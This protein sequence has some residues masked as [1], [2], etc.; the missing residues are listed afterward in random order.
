MMGFK[1]SL[2]GKRIG[3]SPPCANKTFT[4]SA[5]IIVL[6]LP[7]LAAATDVSSDFAVTPPNISEGS[8]PFVM[9]SLSV[10]LTQQG[11]AYTDGEQ[12]YAGG[13]YCP[14]RI[15]GE[16]ICYTSNETYLGYFDPKKCYVYDTSGSNTGN[17]Q[18][19]TGP[20]TGVSPHH[21]RPVGYTDNN[22]QCSSGH[23]YFS[24]NFMNWATMTALD[25]FRGVMT[26][27]ARLVDT[28]GP[29]A[30]TLL[31]RTHRY[32]DWKFVPKKI[33]S[34][35]HGPSSIS[36]SGY[37]FINDA[38][39]LTPFS[40]TVIS[41]D[42]GIGTSYGNRVKF[43]NG[44][45][46]LLGE[47]NVIV[48]VCNPSVGIEDNCTEYTDAGGN[49][50]YKPEGVIQ[51]HALEMR[52]ALSS[53]SA[54]R[55]SIRNG[56]VLRANAKYIGYQRPAQG[57]GLEI[58]PNAE[59]DAQGRYVFNPDNVTLGAGVNNSGI[60]NYINSFAL[61]AAGY[62]YNDPVAELYYEGLRYIKNLGR[63]PEYADAYFGVDGS[64][65]ALTDDEKDN[66]PVIKVWDDPILNACQSTYMIA[67]GDQFA[68]GD[69]SLPGS[70]LNGSGVPAR[71]SNP[72]T[73]INVDTLTDTVGSLEN[74]YPGTLGSQTYALRD[75]NGW[76]LAGL[77]YY[78]NTEDI[79]AD[80]AGVQTVKTF[81]VDTQE[82][83]VAP[84]MREENP[85]WLAAKYGGF[86]DFNGDKDPNNGSPGT[87]NAEWDADGDGDPDNYTLASQPANLIAGLN[88][89]FNVIAERINA[90]SGAA[91]VTNSS[92]GEGAVYQGLY[93]PKFTVGNDRVE[94]VGLLHSLFLDKYGNFREDTDGDGVLTNADTVITFDY[95]TEENKTFVSRYT[96][97]DGGATYTATGEN[98][99]DIEDIDAIWSA[100]DRLAELTDV[101]TQR[102]YTSTANTGRYIFTAIDSDNDGI[103]LTADTLSFDS[104]HFPAASA[105][106]SNN[107]RYL[108]L[109]SADGD[110]APNIV[111]Y[112]RGQ[113]ISGYRS[114]T[115]DY[116]GDGAR[117]VWRLGD[118]I[119]SSP[120]VVTRPA[121][122]YN[123]IY[124]DTTYAEFR[125]QYFD[126]RH[127]IYTGA[128]D[129]L[130]HAFNGGF[131]S[132]E[133]NAFLTAPA[134]RDDITAHPLGT[135]LWAYAPYNLLPHLRW[136]TET[137]YPHVYYVDGI[138]QSFDVNIF[139]NDAT[140]PNGWGTIL[141]VGLRFGGGELTFDPNSDD[142]GDTSDD[143]TTRS[144]YV[145]LDITDPEQAPA[146]VAEISH[147]DMGFATTRPALIKNR[148]PNTTNGSFA[149]PSANDWYLVIGSGPRG[150]DAGTRRQALTD[151][152]SNQDARVLVFDLN[153]KSFITP[154]TDTSFQV[155]D[156]SNGFVGDLTSV[157][158]D[159]DYTDDVVY[160][161]TVQDTVAAPSG[162][163]MRFKPGSN[164]NLSLSSFS[165][166]I[167]KT[168]GVAKPFSGKPHV[169]TSSKGDHWVHMGSGRYYV[170]DDSFSSAQQ[171]Y[172]GIRE[173]TDS[174]GLLTYNT[175]NITDDL[176]DT[177]GIEVF[178]NGTIRRNGSS[179]VS[180]SNGDSVSTFAD[181]KASI[182]SEQGWFFDFEDSMARQ[183]GLS[184]QENV[185]ILFT[186][187]IP[188]GDPCDPLGETFLNAVYFETGTAAPFAALGTD[189]NTTYNSGILASRSASYGVGL[190]RDV[191]LD[192]RA[193]AIG[194]DSTG[195]LKT[196]DIMGPPIPKGRLSWREIDIDW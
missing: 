134:G 69:N 177:T 147:P 66:F 65:A 29:G 195:A 125:Q 104:S 137:E 116:D 189:T 99:I 3:A 76:Y 71:P 135:E 1:N 120:T 46:V 107:F 174:N 159:N 141:V 186:E 38:S 111:N 167:D 136:L 28:A 4:V 100:R 61:S 82:Y 63:T 139:P 143:I 48:E 20:Q 47:Y 110:A 5:A 118:I 117:E 87:S 24:G 124:G 127:V 91:V 190:I 85:L 98:D 40:D 86:D 170:A 121:D 75:Y 73:D 36:M 184:G 17:V 161:G 53:Y 39:K 142:E 42:N 77:T 187:Y 33:S 70:T 58:N 101:T 106:T 129:G 168:G 19:A 144:S 157:D 169:T 176:I 97:S 72:D 152:I 60:I 105:G 88:A 192:S 132:T 153:N 148:K 155:T 59:I 109:T 10:E 182:A 7:A 25:E 37:Q 54:Q 56:G 15:N 49:T 96:T 16:G 57:G 11:E 145:I 191:V 51:K 45:G 92:S 68:W 80:L 64:L 163:L 158:W 27:G 113:E 131:Y 149:T 50:W 115:V 12:T 30:K 123:L 79:R 102:N 188:T 78:A 172:F 164:F 183:V 181:L 44:A 41:V 165:K 185:S 94:W 18:L 22:F 112:I 67:I 146:L 6:L 180:L 93:Q 154:A 95:S 150:S 160:F 26:G 84:P 8:D 130:L 32:G 122:R 35:L 2:S 52:F 62:K 196:Q 14:G 173:P 103:A 194:Q 90:G 166:L 108:G 178:N 171:S 43:Y 13:S 81:V 21:F 179:P 23:G 9:I 133:N 140:H 83:K 31:T 89:A 175:V 193:R 114:R 74:Y 162:Q 151:G 34:A 55:W 156:A 128:N 126:R 138:P 119:S